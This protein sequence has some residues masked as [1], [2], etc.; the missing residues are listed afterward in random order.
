MAKNQPT[1]TYD[2]ETGAFTPAPTKKK[3]R[4][5]LWAVLVPLILICV[6][7]SVF[8][9]KSDPAD[10]ADAPETKTAEAAPAETKPAETDAP[11]T[12]A[13]APETKAPETDPPPTP[14]EIRA[15][16]IASCTAPSY[17]E[18]M[19]RPDEYRKKPVTVTGEV[20]QVLEETHLFTGTTINIRLQDENGDVWLL[21]YNKSDVQTPNGNVLGGDRLTVYGDC[22]GTTSYKNLLGKQITVPTIN[23]KY[24]TE[25]AP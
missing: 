21:I 9:P 15:D 6:I 22:T 1:G 5:C 19:R 3:G 24:M 17:E 10:D 20:V 23:V 14:E 13:P 4:G 12:E 11:E 7:V 8:S 16:Y 2:P 25:A 18:I